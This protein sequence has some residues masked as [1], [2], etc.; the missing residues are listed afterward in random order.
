MFSKVKLWAEKLLFAKLSVIA[1]TL[2]A[3]YGLHLTDRFH[4]LWLS[5]TILQVYHNS[6]SNLPGQ[7]I[8]LSVT[9]RAQEN[10]YLYMVFQKELY[11]VF[12]MLLCGECYEKGLRL[13]H[14]NIWNT[15]VELFLKHTALPVEATLNRNCPR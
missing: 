15:N 12:Q 13:P 2:T 3:V 8:I 6:L 7:G 9:F 14:S 1:F 4:G 10:N 11:S 5:H